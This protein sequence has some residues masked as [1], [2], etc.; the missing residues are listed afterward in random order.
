MVIDLSYQKSLQIVR[1]GRQGAEVSIGSGLDTWIF[2]Q[3]FKI[4]FRIWKFWV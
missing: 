3:R 4:F 2:W 1:I